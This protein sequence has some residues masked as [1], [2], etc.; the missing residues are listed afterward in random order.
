MSIVS[1][2]IFP[3][4]S[5]TLFCNFVHTVATNLYLNPLALVRHQRN[6]QSLI[7]I[8]LRMVYPIAQT[9]GVRLVYLVDSHVYAEALVNFIRAKLRSV[10]D[11]YGENVVNLV[12]CYVLVLHLVPNRVGT[13]DTSLYLILYAHTVESLAYRFCE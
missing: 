11:A 7:A 8:S 2:F 13:L 3:M 12:E 1:I 5:K 4:C 10:D 9:V 6:M